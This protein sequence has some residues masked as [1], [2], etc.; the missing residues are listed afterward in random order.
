M[1]EPASKSSIY[2]TSHA[3]F[4]PENKQFK[5][6]NRIALSVLWK[7]EN[8]T[9]EPNPDMKVGLRL[10]RELLHALLAIET[11]MRVGFEVNQLSPNRSKKAK[12]RLAD[13]A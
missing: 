3:C 5:Q 10:F 13:N 4:M 12:E 8:P 2:H 7:V 6:W 9:K 1:I 11:P